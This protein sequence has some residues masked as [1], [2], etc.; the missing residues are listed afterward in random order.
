MKPIK[1]GANTFMLD[2]LITACW[3][4][5]AGAATASST[6]SSM[7]KIAWQVVTNST[8]TVPFDFC[9]ANVRAITE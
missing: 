1:A 5:A 3:K 6:K 8:A 7:L 9:I 4:P 2:D